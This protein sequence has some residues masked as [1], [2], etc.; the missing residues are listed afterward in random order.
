MVTGV[1]LSKAD[2]IR[3]IVFSFTVTSLHYFVTVHHASTWLD[4][5]LPS[6][7]SFVMAQIQQGTENIPLLS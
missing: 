3:N 6:E 4:S 2:E 1:L 7:L 5:I